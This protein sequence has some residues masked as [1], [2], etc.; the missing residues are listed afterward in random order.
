MQLG[1]GGSVMKMA[2]FWV[3]RCRRRASKIQAVSA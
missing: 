1:Q 2:A 3:G